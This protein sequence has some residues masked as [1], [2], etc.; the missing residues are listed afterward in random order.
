MEITPWRDWEKCVTEIPGH[1]LSFL[2][3]D[4]E[5]TDMEESIKLGRLMN[6]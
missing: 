1:Y 2:D 4:L 5:N 3:M 6:L